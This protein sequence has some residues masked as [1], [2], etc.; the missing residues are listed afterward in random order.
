ML[1]LISDLLDFAKMEKGT[2]SVEPYADRVPNI[3]MPVIDALKPLAD[4]KQQTIECHIE[5]NVPR[6]GGRQPAC[7]E[8]RIQPVEQ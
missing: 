7:C 1:Q 4:A 8:S 2:F 6:S 3:I 5:S